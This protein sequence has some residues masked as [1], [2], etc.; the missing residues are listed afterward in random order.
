MP[1]IVRGDGDGLGYEAKDSSGRQL[2]S[3]PQQYP[4][5]KSLQRNHEPGR[6]LTERGLD[7]TVARL[8]RT[9][10]GTTRSILGFDEARLPVR[11]NERWG[12]FLAADVRDPSWVA[13]VTNQRRKRCQPARAWRPSAWDDTMHP[14][15]SIATWYQ[16]AAGPTAKRQ[17]DHVGRAWTTSEAHECPRN[18]RQAAPPRSALCQPGAAG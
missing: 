10:E 13:L 12:T 8:N 9:E 5:P 3:S 2:V 6:C 11:G 17:K 4:S 7:G 15:E 1:L 16:S 18:T 14:T